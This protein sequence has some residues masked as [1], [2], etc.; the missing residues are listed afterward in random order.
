M[1]SAILSLVVYH[2]AIGSFRIIHGCCAI[3][4]DQVHPAVTC[5]HGVTAA[6]AAA[7]PLAVS[8]LQGSGMPLDAHAS[9][10]ATIYNSARSYQCLD[11]NN[12]RPDEAYCE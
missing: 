11:L 12:S 2:V 1:S 8:L 5:C 10:C 4:S 9:F 7:D 6:A 3:V